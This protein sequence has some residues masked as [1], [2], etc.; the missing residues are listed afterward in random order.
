M[1][2]NEIEAKHKTNRHGRF[3]IDLPLG[4]VFTLS[5]SSPELVG[6]KLLFDTQVS[7]EQTLGDELYFD[8][9]LDLFESIP[10]I[11]KSLL[12]AH[13]ITIS[14]D[15][16]ANN[17]TYDQ[18]EYD[19]LRSQLD[20]INKV[21][22]IYEARGPEYRN[23]LR[24]AEEYFLNGDFD[25]AYNHL[26]N[27]K[28]IFEGDTF[29]QNRLHLVERA[30][31]HERLAHIANVA[32]ISL[33]ASNHSQIS[34]SG[35]SIENIDVISLTTEIADYAPQL[36]QEI[37]QNN[38]VFSLPLTPD[39]TP[40]MGSGVYFMV[41]VLATNGT[42]YKNFFSPIIE[43]TPDNPI[44]QYRDSDGLNKFAVGLHTNLRDAMNLLRTLRSLNYDT[45]IVAFYDGRR[46][47]VNEALELQSKASQ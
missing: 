8:F 33:H 16:L 46:V 21:A 7:T 23:L 27:A 5:I 41:Q 6:K 36:S 37:T 45:Y 24:K 38:I 12:E 26:S 18:I 20:A 29:V 19:N 44:L 42:P 10:W 35:D 31:H 32:E 43:N 28:S 13:L 17:F 25:A 15:N 1:D 22:L 9:A 11:D 4:G 47:R 40:T 14:F 2:G 30:L 39:K 3:V 34:D